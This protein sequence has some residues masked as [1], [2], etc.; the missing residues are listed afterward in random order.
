[1]TPHAAVTGEAPP[2]APATPLEELY[3]ARATRFEAEAARLGARSRGVSHLRGAAFLVA[4]LG[5]LWGVLGGPRGAAL[6]VVAAGLVAFLGLVVAHARVIALEDTA[7]RWARVNE[8]AQLRLSGRFSELPRDGAR[9]LSARHAYASDLD[10]FGP[11]SVFQRVSVARTRWGEDTLADWLLGPAEPQAIVRRQAAVR[12][13]APRLDLRQ[14]IEALGL[15]LR[16]LR[17]RGTSGAAPVVEPSDPEAMLG[18]AEGK[19][20]LAGRPLLLVAARG[21]P[22]WTV[23]VAV[24]VGVA[25]APLYALLVPLAL[26]IGVDL[27]TRA[28]TH[29]AFQA[30]TAGEGALAR[31]QAA[32]AA[33]ERATLDPEIHAALGDP[34]AGGA[35]RPSEALRALRRAVG[36]LALRENALLHPV[37][38]AF[39]LWDLNWALA[40]DGWRGRYGAA[41]RGWFRALGELEA[42]S[43]FA[44]LHHDEPEWTFLELGAD[45]EPLEALGVSHPLLP[46][47]ARVGNDVSLSG[48]G[49]ALLVT[50]SNMSGKST[51][52]RAVGLAVVLGLAGAPVCARRLRLGPVA[53][54]TSMRVSDSLAQGASHF[55]V[56]V[57]R[58][59]Y[60]LAGTRQPTRLL[61]LLDEI[62]HGTNS[63]ER[64]IGGRWVIA[65][66]VRQGALGLVSTHDMG[67]VELPPEVAPAVRIVHFREAVTDGVMTFDYRLRDGPVTEGNALR[68]MRALG[69]AVPE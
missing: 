28:A 68:L 20:E 60:V 25:D 4:G 49:T 23:A 41:A 38:N 5:G 57:S 13:F 27:R 39:L 47:G 32:L 34:L 18:W 69:L 10:L 58:L 2:R 19:P 6:A 67:L 44:A 8:E 3:R 31:H 16:E 64:Q 52:L 11:A 12:A 29:R 59:A 56:E 51:L 40:L 65:E 45:G 22:L 62:L 61:F 7:R 66:L 54:R 55:Y 46:G 24:A 14:E 53:L 21:L 15:E 17:P 30:V 37:V 33:V 42:L 26:A 50:G 48:P 9:F 36:W 63:R 1:M 43:S 35:A